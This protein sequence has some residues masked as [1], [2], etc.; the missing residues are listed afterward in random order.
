MLILRGAT[1]RRLK[2]AVQRLI[3]A[4]R[5]ED[6][7]LSFPDAALAGKPWIPQRE[8]A[9][10]PWAP[11]HVRGVFL[12]PYADN[13]MDIW[14]SGDMQLARYVDLFDWLGFSGVQLIETTYNWGVMGSADAYHAPLLRI[15]RDARLDGQDVTL[16]V[17]GAEVTSYEWRDP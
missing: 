13:R 3:I 17:W 8:W 14:Q 12:N 9:L 16:W 7:G 1:D 2:R 6:G 4:S 10:C 11:Q 15:A 5:Q